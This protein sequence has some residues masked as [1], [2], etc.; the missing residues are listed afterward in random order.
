M[1]LMEPAGNLEKA[2][3]AAGCFWGVEAVFRRVEGVIETAVGYT[4][5][6]KPEPTYEEVCSGTTGHAESVELLFDPARVTYD[7][8]LDIFWENHDPT[9]VNGQGPDTG[10]SYRSVI[11]YHTEEQRKKAEASKARLQASGKYSRPVVTE[12]VPAG[13]F[14]RAEE[15]HQQFYEKSGRGYCAAP[16]YWE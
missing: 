7:R 1:L 6:T 9:Q 8:L 4:G 5:G 15:Y 12:I 2:T 14:W 10:S 11:F 13:T 3:F 16:K